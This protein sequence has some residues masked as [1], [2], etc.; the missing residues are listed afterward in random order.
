VIGG[1]FAEECRPRRVRPA[2]PIDSGRWARSA[3][4][5]TARHRPATARHRP[6]TCDH[7][8]GQ[9]GQRRA[10]CRVAAS[11]VAPSGAARLCQM[12]TRSVKWHA[13]PPDLTPDRTDCGFC[14]PTIL[15]RVAR[16]RVCHE[17]EPMTLTLTGTPCPTTSRCQV[18]RRPRP[19]SDICPPTPTTAPHEPNPP[20]ARAH[21]LAW[22]TWAPRGPAGSRTREAPSTVKWLAEGNQDSRRD[23]LVNIVCVH[24]GDPVLKS[25]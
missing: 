4:V 6:G 7:A 19:P 13:L 10:G 12:P 9:P 22:P 20:E 25:L 8:K 3:P 18:S 17:S 21:P 23:T 11:R 15:P 14:A 2:R 24:E 16:V 1:L 5:G